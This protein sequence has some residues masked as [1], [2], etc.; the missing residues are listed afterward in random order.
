MQMKTSY[1]EKMLRSFVKKVFQNEKIYF[2]VRLKQIVNP[3]TNMPLELDIFIPEKK[4]AFEFHGRQHKTDEYQRY[5]DKIKRQKCKE[6][7]IHLFEIWTANLNKDLLQ[8]IEKECTTL[9][10]KITTPSTTFLNKFDK[11]GNEYKKQIY[12]MNTKIHSKTFVSK[13]GK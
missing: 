11:L 8:R 3:E 7:G 10:I 2:N 13:K 4:L 1:G 9:G 6:I 12:K 5:K